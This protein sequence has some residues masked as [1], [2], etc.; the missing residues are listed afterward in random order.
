MTTYKL[1]ILKAFKNGTFRSNVIEFEAI[2]ASFKHAA[3]S[4][5]AENKEYQDCFLF[6]PETLCPITFDFTY[7]FKAVTGNS[8]PVDRF[9]LTYADMIKQLNETIER[10]DLVSTSIRPFVRTLYS[11]A[12]KLGEFLNMHGGTNIN[13]D[14]EGK[15][16]SL[17]FGPHFDTLDRTKFLNNRAA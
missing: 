4:L 8:V 14:M 3:L 9:A 10:P 16:D 13:M 7:H 11:N 6:C 2:G 15:E 5:I 12:G 17:F 1:G